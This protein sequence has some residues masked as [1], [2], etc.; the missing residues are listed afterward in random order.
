MENYFRRFFFVPTFAPSDRKTVNSINKLKQR[1]KYGKK[2]KKREGEADGGRSG[3]NL[4][5]RRRRSSEPA[6]KIFGWLGRSFQLRQ[7]SLR[8]PHQSV[9]RIVSVETGDE[10]SRLAQVP[11]VEE[12]GEAAAVLPMLEYESGALETPN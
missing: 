12:E 3:D 6:K 2:W 5:R 9:L 8:H 11:T 1:K 7:E 10:Q 4:R